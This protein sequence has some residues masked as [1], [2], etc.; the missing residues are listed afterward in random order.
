LAK[1]ETGAHS[2]GKGGE[3]GFL[4]TVSVEFVI[5]G[6]SK[7]L[8]ATILDAVDAS[9]IVFKIDTENPPDTS[10][11]SPTWVKCQLE[12]KMAYF[13]HTFNPS[14]RYLPIGATPLLKLK[15]LVGQWLMPAFRTLIS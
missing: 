7:L 12:M 8:M 5:S 1:Q 14:S 10:V 9:R 15:L 13:K 2:E 11:P 3:V 4:S 6:L